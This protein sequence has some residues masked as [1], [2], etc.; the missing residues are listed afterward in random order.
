MC[1]FMTFGTLDFMDFHGEAYSFSYF[2]L[3][4]FNSYF[5]SILLNQ[6]ESKEGKNERRKEAGRKETRKQGRKETK[7]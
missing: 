4:F 6:E 2:L 5:V 7:K 1:F 3:L